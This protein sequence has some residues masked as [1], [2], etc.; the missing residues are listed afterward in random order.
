[1]TK[2]LVIDDLR[3]FRDEYHRDEVVYAR[4][5]K[6]GLTRLNSFDQLDELWLDHDLGMVDGEVDSIMPVID[7]LSFLAMNETPFQVDQ[8][9]VHTSNPVGAEQM[10]RSLNRWGYRAVKVDAS[11]FFIVET[12]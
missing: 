3:S 11:Q 1:M 8:I 5:S 9:F 12:D 2:L 4:T 10:M 7:H 6:E